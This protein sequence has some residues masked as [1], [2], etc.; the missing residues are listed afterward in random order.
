[1]NIAQDLYLLFFLAKVA[2]DESNSIEVRVSA[3]KE[4]AKYVSPQLKAVETKDT[5]ETEKVYRK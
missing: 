3:A 2:M 4:V 1:M 5:T